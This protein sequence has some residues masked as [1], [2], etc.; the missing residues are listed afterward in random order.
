MKL[1]M[2]IALIASLCTA[3]ARISGEQPHGKP[4][5]AD[6]PALETY[7]GQNA[8]LILTKNE[9]GFRTRLRYASKQ[10]P[11]FAGHYVLTAW[12]CGAECLMGA[13]I[14]ANTGRVYWVPFTIC[15]W[16]DSVD[17]PIEYRLHS[18][19][20]IFSGLR[21][22]KDGDGGVHYYEFTGHNF[23]Q[24]RSDDQGPVP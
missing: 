9:T 17:R 11:N 21:D 2:T 13:V 4:Q 18:R 19:L 20:L 1:S 8:P 5:F 10:K 24:I 15:C 16:P 6:Y 12:G 23:V 14:D 7:K 22:E 3:V